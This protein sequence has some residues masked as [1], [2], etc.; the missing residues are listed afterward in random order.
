MIVVLYSTRQ[1]QGWHVDQGRAL[2]AF[3]IASGMQRLI[4][5]GLVL[6]TQFGLLVHIQE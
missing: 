5:V 1:G 3:R 2:A 4:P 6:T